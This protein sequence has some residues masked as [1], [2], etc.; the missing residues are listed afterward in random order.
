[1]GAKSRQRP[2]YNFQEKGIFGQDQLA[3]G[4]ASAESFQGLLSASEIGNEI[5]VD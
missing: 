3:G 4:Q 1:L 2:S 5:A